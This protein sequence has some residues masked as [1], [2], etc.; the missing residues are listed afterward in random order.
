MTREVCRMELQPSTGS[1]VTRGANQIRL[2]QS[3]AVLSAFSVRK[4]SYN[5]EVSLCSPL[6]GHTGAGIGCGVHWAHFE[7]R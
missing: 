1:A 3:A 2:T 5:Y 4:T 7:R 6:G